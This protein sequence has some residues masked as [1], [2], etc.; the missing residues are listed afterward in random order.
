MHYAA[1]QGV[2][3]TDASSVKNAVEVRVFLHA[4]M[5]FVDN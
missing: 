3:I 5:I 1:K 4:F 2:T